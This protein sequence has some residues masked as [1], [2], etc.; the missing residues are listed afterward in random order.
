MSTQRLYRSRVNKVFAGVCGGLAEYFDVDPVIIRII[1]VLMVFFGGSGILLYIAALIIIPQKP[2]TIADF[3]KPPVDSA[4]QT[5]PAGSSA[6]NWFGY[7]LVIVGVLILMGNLG[8]FDIFDHFDNVFEFI[9]PVLLILL[10]MGIIYYRQSQPINSQSSEAAEPS[11][12]ESG[13]QGEHD[14]NHRQ[15]ASYRQFR[16]SYTDKK[17]AGVCGGMAQYFDIDPSIIRML[18]VILCLASFGAG[19]V[20]YIVLALV[21]PYDYAY[22]S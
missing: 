15:S 5:L 7:F 21:V 17:I 6:R 22:K 11:G 12:E 10:G 16:R 13:T 19:L 3:E 1:F 18:Y 20:L 9:F 8:V 2:Y 4:P 14:Q